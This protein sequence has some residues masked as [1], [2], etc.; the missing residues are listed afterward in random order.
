MRI[1]VIEDEKRL[2]AALKRGLEA[3]GYSVDVA[4]DGRTGLWMGMENS[5]DAVVLD[6]MLPEMN[7]FQVCRQLREAGKWAPILMLTAKDGELDEAAALDTGADDFLCAAAAFRNH[8][9]EAQRKELSRLSSDL[10]LT[11]IV[12]PQLPVA[13]VAAT[14]LP[15]LAAALLQQI[16]TLVG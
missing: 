9:R 16:A 11:Q 12:L 5:Y 4:L 13:G 10:A 14:D 2:V 7:G 1:L 3:E 6:I 15:E 8:R